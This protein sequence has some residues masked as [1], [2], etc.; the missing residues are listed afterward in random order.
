MQRTIKLRWWIFGLL[1]A[2]N[3]VNNFDRQVL[4]ISAPTLQHEMGWSDLD[5]GRMVSAFQFTFAVMSL[6]LGVMI[7]RLGARLSM[8]AAILW[9]SLAQFAH[10]F[11]RGA[12]GFMAARIGLALGEAPVYPATLKAMAEWAPREERG[13]A[14]GIVHFGVMIGALAA[15]LF[16]PWLIT[17]YGWQSGFLFTGALGFIVLIPWML[18]FHA[19]ETSPRITQQERD[20]ILNNRTVSGPA[21]RLPWLALFK[22][23][24]LWV[25][26]TIQAVVNPAWWFLIYWLPKFF[27]EAFGIKG[28][29]MT[30]YLSTIFAVASF[31]AVGGGALSG[32]LLKRGFSLN[33]SR[34]LT[35]LACGLVMPVI[36]VA[37]TTKSPWTAVLVIS[38]AA[39]VHQT[40]TATGAAVLADLFPPRAIASVVG[41]GSFCGSLAGVAGAEATGRLLVAHPGHY[42]PMF[43]YAALAYLAATA[44]VQLL[45]PRLEPTQAI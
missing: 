39:I 38:I 4:A 24:Q 27:S 8:F 13:A 29:G 19:P 31:G 43:A 25:Y 41:I 1:M 28:T 12:G 26:V 16:L 6:F 10:I 40:W 33:L 37:V 42:A 17:R 14:A 44:I 11:A 30:P 23:R 21:P 18:L 9:F 32:V 36:L 45:S 34:K 35:M 7:D 15:P 3:L 20:L 22:A 2:I 5:Y